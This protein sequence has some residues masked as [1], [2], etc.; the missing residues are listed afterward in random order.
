MKLRLVVVLLAV[1]CGSA[2]AKR[3]PPS[4]TAKPPSAIASDKAMLRPPA[5][6]PPVAKAASEP[7]L[8]ASLLLVQDDL[9]ATL[10]RTTPAFE[11]GRLADEPASASYDSWHFKATGQPESHDLAFRIWR[12]PATELD[13]KWQDL[14]TGLPNVVD[15]APIAGARAFNA[16]EPGDKIFGHAFHDKQ[17]RVIVL[18]TCGTDLCK[19]T[20]EARAFATLI[21]G[22]LG[23]LP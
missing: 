5:V 19:T 6:K 13:T 1:G 21:H 14:K 7:L 22:R 3:P 12:L 20:D 16:R 2:P 23:R 17:R 10:R 4:S 15:A 9:A 8:D 11:A 18:V